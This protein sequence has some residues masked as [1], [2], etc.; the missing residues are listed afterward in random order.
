MFLRRKIFS[1]FLVA[2]ILSTVFA[3]SASAYEA[4]VAIESTRISTVNERDSAVTT[5]NQ[6]LMEYDGETITENL[7][8]T[9]T[10]NLKLNAVSPLAIDD[11]VVLKGSALFTEQGVGAHYYAF[12]G[13]GTGY[14]E[15][16]SNIKLPTGFNNRNIRNGYISLGVTGTAHGVDMGLRNSGSGW[17]PYVY[18]VGHNFSAFTQ[19]TAPRT[20]TNA[21]IVVKPIST[22]KIAMYIRF[23][24]AAGQTVGTT[25][26]RTITVSSGNFVYSGGRIACRYYRFA[27]LVPTGNDNQSDGTY[28]TGGQFTNCQL[29]NR[30]NYVSWGIN[31]PRVTN[32]WKVSSSKITLTYGA[33]N[34]SFNIRHF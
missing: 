11:V 29:Y 13:Y 25:F 34:D 18:D 26:D 1:I 2:S 27:S 12:S 3:V 22:T 7:P 4:P 8:K 15:A 21:V 9:T 5:N 31:T 32:A 33:T 14:S 24:N 17:H 10:G 28:M 16:F 6:F 19:Y 23:V 30:S 20:A